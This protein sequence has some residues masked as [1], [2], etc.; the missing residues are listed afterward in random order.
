MKRPSKA[1]TTLVTVE[2]F[3]R[4]VP[5]GQKADLLDG[6]IYMASP[7]TE[8]ADDLTGFVAFLVRGYNDARRLGGRVFGSRF[9]FRLSRYRAPEPDV[10]YVRRER[11]HLVRKREMKGGPDVAIEIV[12]RDS[13]TRDYRDKKEIYQKASVAEYWIIDP[14]KQQVQFHRLREGRYELVPLERG[15]IFRSEVLPGFWL[16]VRW[17]L[18]EPLP[19]G[20]ACLH[21]ILASVGP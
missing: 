12:S 18:A 19:N 7:D 1:P 6:V 10:A 8:R 13:V 17:L 21:E 9:S 2:E 15:H 14:L 16:D 11:L 20:Y 4:L 5:D 3:Y